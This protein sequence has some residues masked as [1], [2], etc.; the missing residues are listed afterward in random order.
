MGDIALTIGVALGTAA[1]GVL[2]G[3][4]V[5]IIA[6]HFCPQP[7]LP[8]TTEITTATVFGLLGWKIGLDPLLPAYLYAAGTGVALSLIDLRTRRLPDALTLPSYV[9]LPALVA[10]G[11]ITSKEEQFLVGMLLGALA[12]FLLYLSFHRINTALG[13]GDVKAS[14]LAGGVL[15]TLGANAWILGIGAGLVLAALYA[16]ALLTRGKGT[17]STLMPY[18]PFMFAGCLVGILTA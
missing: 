6:A 17:G 7:G 12:A 11:A 9:I 14:G 5:L 13:G 1:I 8:Y 3:R 16:V 10:I 15:G 4:T 2:T 18:G